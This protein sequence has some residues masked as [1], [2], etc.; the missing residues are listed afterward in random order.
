MTRLLINAGD[1]EEVRV[2]L[3]EN[4]ELHEF[5]VERASSQEIIGNIYLA[6][7]ARIDNRHEAA[8]VDFGH[9]RD[10]F[11]PLAD[12]PMHLD[13]PSRFKAGTLIP[14]QVKREPVGTKGAA[15]T[16]FI[17]LPGRFSVVM[18]GADSGGV[19]RKITNDKERDRLRDM[20]K[21]IERPKGF[22]IILRTAAIDQT[23][24]AIETDIKR[25]LRVWKKLE[26]ESKK[27]NS[28]C[29]LFRETDPYMR[30]LRDLLGIKLS[31]V[32]V[33]TPHAKERVEMHLG[34][35]GSRTKIP[36][37]LHTG[38]RPLFEVAG[39]EAQIARLSERNVPLPGGGSI[40]IDQTEA[41]VAIDVNSGRT[42][43]QSADL[44]AVRS[45]LEAAKVIAREIRLRD[46]GGIIV[47]DFIDME[48][49]AEK[50][51]VEK[52][53]KTAMKG[54]RS[55]HRIY[56]IGPT[57]TL[58]MTRKRMRSRGNQL[59]EV[60][61]DHC[62]GRGSIP[63]TRYQASEVRRR[64]EAQL[65]RGM[66]W[67][68]RLTV[69]LPLSVS[70]ELSNRFRGALAELEAT[71][72]CE[73]VILADA[74]ADS[75]AP[76]ELRERSRD[77]KGSDEPRVSAEEPRVSAEEPRVSTEEPLQGE[78]SDAPPETGNDDEAEDAPPKK[79][80]RRRRRGG[81]KKVESNGVFLQRCDAH[82]S[83]VPNL[84][85]E[86]ITG[87]GAVERGAQPTLPPS[88]GPAEVAAQAPSALPALA[89]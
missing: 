73:V 81:A 62:G 55:R 89:P 72:R 24:T 74:H 28:P 68:E 83:T 2:A 26:A 50:R 66:G 17:S 19:S 9:A 76:F 37:T 65:R 43:G 61:C 49:S 35:L 85:E 10:G 57:G 13:N 31:E 53:F 71:Y 42:K 22:G 27:T 5:L 39:I 16:G 45:N 32:V 44:V 77:A 29:L 86:L 8:F 6:K 34:Q 38:K 54:D 64:I 21:K 7:V 12:I 4:K 46:L 70:N 78:I 40:V 75:A 52:T 67:V 56:S 48:R 63:S 82:R 47:I 18:P 1:G 80:R 84:L 60:V 15:L 30:I 51:E 20:L 59:D 33:D 23:K 88:S 41:L 11:V 14:V 79:R 58:D 3:A 69:R 36:V 87:L 25:S